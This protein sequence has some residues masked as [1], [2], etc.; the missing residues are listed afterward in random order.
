MKQYTIITLCFFM[1]IAC[2]DN[3]QIIEESRQAHLDSAKIDSVNFQKL[4][5]K[6]EKLNGII[7]DGRV[8]SVQQLDSIFAGK[9]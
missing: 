7:L 8:Y 9:K 6:D 5:Q 3:K 1:L 4:K 2:K